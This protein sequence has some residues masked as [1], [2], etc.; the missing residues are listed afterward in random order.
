MGRANELNGYDN[1]KAFLAHILLQLFT[2]E[3]PGFFTEYCKL[4]QPNPH[5]RPNLDKHC[6]RFC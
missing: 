6:Q 5:Q 2:D 1:S 4:Y 3:F